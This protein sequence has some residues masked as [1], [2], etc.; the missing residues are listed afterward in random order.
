MLYDNALLISVISE[1][2]Q[3]TGKKLYRET[4]E[5]TMQFIMKEWQDSDGGFFS[6][7][8]ADSEGIEGKY[9]T[10]DIAELKIL[11]SDPEDFEIFTAY[12]GVE[13]NG[14]WEHTNILW[15]QQSVDI[16]CAAR[17][18]DPETIEVLLG[19]CRNILLKS[20]NNRVRPLLDD[21]KLMSWNALMITACCK[22]WIATG[23][24]NYLKMAEQAVDFIETKMKSAD[25]HYYH[26]Y[27]NGKAANPAFL[28]DMACYIQ[29]LCYLQECT[30]NTQYLETATRLTNKVLSLFHD[31]LSGFFFYTPNY[32]DDIVFRKKDMYDGATPSGNS[33]MA[34]NLFYLGSLLGK[35]DWKEQSIL[36]MSKMKKLVTSYPGSFALWAQLLQWQVYEMK[37]IAVIGAACKKITAQLLQFYIPNKVVQ[38]AATSN[39]KY[40]LLSNKVLNSD[41]TFI[42]LCYRFSCRQP[43]KTVDEFISM[44]NNSQGY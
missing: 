16:F 37:E 14:N 5:Q 6:A 23:I 38:Q 44:I 11:L 24:D 4:I 2:Y 22:A 21:K 12:Y 10:W 40:P 25:D 42:Y 27:K 9:Y 26:N 13:E 7:Y 15:V 34:N 8:D 1:A 41:Q 39:K 18:L 30:G 17:G 32:Q 28:E 3:L 20:R 43:V 33:L 31:E 35:N 19:R 36:M 29:S